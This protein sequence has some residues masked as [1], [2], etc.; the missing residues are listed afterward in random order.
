MTSFIAQ[1]HSTLLPGTRSGAAVFHKTLTPYT[2]SPS[3]FFI[4]STPIPE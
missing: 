2:Q 1:T 4:F 3:A